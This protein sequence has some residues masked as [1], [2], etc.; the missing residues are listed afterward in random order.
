M[1]LVHQKLYQFQMIYDKIT[2][3]SNEAIVWM[4]QKLTIAMQIITLLNWISL[5]FW[6]IFIVLKV[7]NY[8]L[9]GRQ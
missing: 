8:Y 9:F 5:Y 3:Y 7:K 4:S 2:V 1:D 6:I